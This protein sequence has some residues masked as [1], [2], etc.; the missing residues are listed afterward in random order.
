MKKGIVVLSL[1]DGYSGA[2]L[3]L[4]KLGVKVK[5][6]YASEIDPYAIWV[7]QKNFP[8]TIQLGDITKLK[9]AKLAALPPI[10]LLIGGSP[11]Q[12]FSFAGKQ[13]NF[14]D[15]RSKLFFEFVRI[16]KA[17]N[18]TL[19]LLENVPMNKESRQIISKKM[20]VLPLEINSTLVSAQN[21]K[22]LYWTNIT[23]RGRPIPQPTDRHIYF[24]DILQK[25]VAKQYYV[26][27]KG[28]DFTFAS[29]FLVDYSF[30]KHNGPRYYE[31]KAPTLQARDYKEPRCVAIRTR[32]YRGQGAQL[33]VN[34]HRKSN[35]LNTVSKDNMVLLKSPCLH[36]FAHGT[37]GQF[38][39]QL[40]AGG[41][42]RRLTPVECER[43]Q[44]VPDNY[45]EG[46]SKTQWYKMLGNGFNV[47]TVAHI[48][49]FAFGR[50][51]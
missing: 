32:N 48:L 24:K 25:K 40:K 22:R 31:K 36:G 19:F 33:E 27:P 51:R 29:S 41:L 23:H 4:Q 30:S 47:D 28:I 37:N 34:K 35:T 46:V 38:N 42:L 13:L 20:E 15:P 43:L 11:C 26:S 8:K 18:P 17:V 2:Q 39:K 3:A 12:G 21:R 45:T 9:G 1:F 5:A 6:Y 49:S 44:T 7:T 10:D 16:K 50:Q 14:N